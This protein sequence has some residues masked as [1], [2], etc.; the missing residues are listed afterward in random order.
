MIILTWVLLI[1][2]NHSEQMEQAPIS[3][4]WGIAMVKEECKISREEDRYNELVSDHSLMMM[5]MMV[6]IIW[7]MTQLSGDAF[8]VQSD[9]ML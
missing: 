1:L 7:L 9:D 8:K 6:I 3:F 5:M 2:A 4:Q